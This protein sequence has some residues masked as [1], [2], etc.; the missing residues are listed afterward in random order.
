M[1]VQG[2]IAKERSKVLSIWHPPSADADR[3]LEAIRAA[4]KTCFAQESILRVDAGRA[5]VL[6]GSVHRFDNLTHEES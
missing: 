5:W 6:E 1:A 4:Y 2:A 3:Q